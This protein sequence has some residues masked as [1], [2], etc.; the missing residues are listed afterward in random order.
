MGKER[1]T[2]L[3]LVRHRI[4][5]LLVLG[6]GFLVVPSHLCMNAK[7]NWSRYCR[8]YLGSA[9]GR[10]H[11]LLGLTSSFCFVDVLQTGEHASFK[12]SGRWY[13]T[14]MHLRFQ[15]HDLDK[16]FLREVESPVIY[17]GLSLWAYLVASFLAGGVHRLYLLR[18]HLRLLY[19][20][21]AG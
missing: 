2:P 8:T 16:Q 14:L 17:F 20:S 1:L 7:D 6:A 13:S 4:T 21:A 3:F 11:G 12:M 19:L 5:P 10:R 9:C 15:Q 18:H